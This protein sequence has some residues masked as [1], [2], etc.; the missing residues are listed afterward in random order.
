MDEMLMRE[1]YSETIADAKMWLNYWARYVNG[2]ALTELSRVLGG[3]YG[4]NWL[5]VGDLRGTK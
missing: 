5:T 1:H 4:A 2:I 3:C